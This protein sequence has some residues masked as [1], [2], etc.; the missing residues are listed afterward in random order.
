MVAL[1]RVWDGLPGPVRVLAGG[2][3]LALRCS[4][5]GGCR[6][7]P[8]D[9]HLVAGPDETSPA[10]PACADVIVGARGEPARLLQAHPGCLVAVTVTGPGCAVAARGL[11]ARLDPVLGGT[12]TAGDA[13]LY[14]SALH[15]LLVTGGPLDALT[16]LTL[17]RGSTAT[18]VRVRRRRARP[19]GERRA[20][21]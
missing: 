16:R 20:A 10:W 1:V 18:M 4:P 5:V 14:A 11:D 6:P 21:L 8:C 19:P 12:C 7:P 9:E 2:R 13:A 15:A 17:V 3:A